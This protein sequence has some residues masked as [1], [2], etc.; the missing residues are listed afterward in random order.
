MVKIWANR[1]IAG[2]FSYTND[3]PAI[4]KEAVKAELLSR[5]EKGEI[6]QERYDEIIAN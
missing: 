1:L 4:R 6:L 2:T 3:V 5:V